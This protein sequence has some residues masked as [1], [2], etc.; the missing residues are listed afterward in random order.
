MKHFSI[1]HMFQRQSNLSEPIKN[2]ILVEENTTL[3]L[4]SRMQITAITIVHHNKQ[5]IRI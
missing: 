3:G 1:V 2:L 5:T 4:D